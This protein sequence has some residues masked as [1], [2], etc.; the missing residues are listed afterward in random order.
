[1]SVYSLVCNPLLLLISYLL[2]QV[3]LVL[4]QYELN[5]GL[6]NAMV[7]SQFIELLSDKQI[8]LILAF[9]LELFHE[10]ILL[11]SVSITL[12]VIK[13]GYDVALVGILVMTWQ[14]V[15]ILLRNYFLCSIFLFWE[16]SFRQLSNIDSL[17]FSDPSLQLLH[18]KIK[19]FCVFA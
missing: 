15:H 9:K 8:F 3:F 13:F 2:F 6:F 18:L 7:P 17:K 14:L 4:L 5:I 11:V 1:M 19:L 10:D 12:D 16:R